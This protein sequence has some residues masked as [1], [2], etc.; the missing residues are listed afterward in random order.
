MHLIIE[1]TYELIDEFEKSSL[2]K[3]LTLSKENILKDN[4][5]LEKIKYLNTLDDYSKSIEKAKL[6]ENK[7]YNIYMKCVSEIN[8]LVF[9][10]NNKLKKHLEKEKHHENY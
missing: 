2:I 8:Y 5:L 9:S 3:E 1:K 6:Y 7:D 4:N 10:F